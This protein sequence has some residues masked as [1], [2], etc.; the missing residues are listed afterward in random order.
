MYYVVISKFGSGTLSA[1][2][3]AKGEVL[4]TYLLFSSSLS[5][6]YSASRKSPPLGGLFLPGL[7]RLLG[8][9]RVLADLAPGVMRFGRN[10]PT[11]LV[12]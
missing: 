5:P 4:F 10:S 2:G 8:P 11:L 1:L 7:V 12:P 3:L 6:P 9:T